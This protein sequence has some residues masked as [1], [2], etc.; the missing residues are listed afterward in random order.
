MNKLPWMLLLIPLIFITTDAV[1][2]QEEISN[3][4]RNV[5]MHFRRYPI[6]GIRQYA[7]L[8][9]LPADH[10][11]NI[12]NLVQERLRRIDANMMRGSSFGVARFRRSNGQHTEPRV[13]SLLPTLLDEYRVA[14][15]ADPPTV[16]LYTRGTPCSDCTR[17]ILNARD[18]FLP[19]REFVVAYSENMFNRYMNPTLNCQNRNTLRVFDIDVYC[20]REPGRSSQC[21][22]NDNLPACFQHTG[23]S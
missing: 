21:T 4:V 5:A 8:M 19:R 22:E 20:V 1:Y 10:N 13:L 23:H 3:I 7:V 16:L 6:E 12:V 18:N 2:T 9:V 15:G 14:F 11:V 17:S